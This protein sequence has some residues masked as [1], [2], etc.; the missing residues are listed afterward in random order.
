LARICYS[1][2][3]LRIGYTYISRVQA[4]VRAVD[5]SAELNVFGVLQ[6]VFGFQLDNCRCQRDNAISIVGSRLTR[7]ADDGIGSSA[8]ELEILSAYRDELLN[9]YRCATLRPA[10]AEACL[11]IALTSCTFNVS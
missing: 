5:S 4:E 11:T 1:F 2:V 6:P 10:N 7:T 8:A 3:N 9:N